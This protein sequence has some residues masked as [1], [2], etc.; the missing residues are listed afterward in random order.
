MCGMYGADGMHVL[1][2]LYG[3]YRVCMETYV[4]CMVWMVFCAFCMV[5]MVC[6]AKLGNACGN[7]SR[8]ACNVCTVAYRRHVCLASTID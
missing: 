1:D 2:D 3:F 7:A 8:Y 5:C 4:W 6:T